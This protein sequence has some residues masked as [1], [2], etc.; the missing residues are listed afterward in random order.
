REE[1][2]IAK[3]R[4]GFLSL[5]KGWGTRGPHA[6]GPQAGI[7]YSRGGRKMLP[8]GALG[9]SRQSGGLRLPAPAALLRSP[10]SSP[11]HPSATE[12]PTIGIWK[13]NAKLGAH[14]IQLETGRIARQAE[15]AVL[16]RARGTV[17]LCA[18]SAAEEARAGVDFLPLT[19]EYRERLSAAGRF[20]G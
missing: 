18:V 14:L 8:L 19:V 16:V 15:S 2:T 13:G 9:R 11:Y 20:P 1:N 17:L 10:L 12:D 5:T 6:Q 4:M 7:S 3:I